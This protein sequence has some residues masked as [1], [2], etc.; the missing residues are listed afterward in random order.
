MR[1]L[2]DAYEDE[3]HA[4]AHSIRKDVVPVCQ[5][6]SLRVKNYYSK[7]FGLQHMNI[8]HSGWKCAML[9]RP[10]KSPLIPELERSCV[11][12]VLISS[13]RLGSQQSMNGGIGEGI[14]FHCRGER[15]S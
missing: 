8:I 14:E 13:S 7:I 15:K 3:T 10:G 12:M 5:H 1:D 6:Q 11:G 4:G 9:T 2:E